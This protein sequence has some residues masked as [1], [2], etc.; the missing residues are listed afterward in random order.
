M[1]LYEVFP[2]LEDGKKIKRQNWSGNYVV[3][4]GQLRRV[5]D[6]QG[7]ETFIITKE[8]L[9]A[10]DWEIVEDIPEVEVHVNIERYYYCPKCDH[11][12]PIFSDTERAKCNRCG[13]EVKL[14]RPEEPKK[15][16]T[17]YDIETIVTEDGNV[18]CNYKYHPKIMP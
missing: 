14:K 2:A 3:L 15:L 8:N 10:E 7:S 11:G 1:K 12:V 17:P 6:F 16:L 4:D 5:F 9:F 13:Q 18:F